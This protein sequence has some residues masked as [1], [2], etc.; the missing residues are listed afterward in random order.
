MATR[1]EADLVLQQYQDRLFDSNPNLVKLSVVPVT[2]VDGRSTSEYLLEAGV[3]SMAVQIAASSSKSGEFVPEGLA[4]PDSWNGNEVPV[5][6]IQVGEIKALNNRHSAVSAPV[7]TLEFVGRVRPVNGG[8]SVGNTRFNSAG[9]FGSV[10]KLR[11]D[12]RN[13][14]F[15]SNWHV[16]AGGAGVPGDAI[17]QP[18]RLD[19]GSTPNDEIGSLFWF[20]LNDEF[21]VALGL[22]RAP[23][24]NFVAHG[25]RCFSAYSDVPVDP[26]VGRHVTKCGRTTETTHGTILSTNAT[27]RVTGAYPGGVQRFVKQIETTGMAMA[28]D[29]GSVTFHSADMSP[30]GLLFAGDSTRTYHNNLKKLFDTQFG[31]V[32]TTN[33]IGTPITLPSVQ[34]ERL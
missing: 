6:V 1:A 4:V 10:V 20:L 2:D 3:I 23:W 15:I 27:V 7:G 22:S 14:Y 30:V 8:N 28:G 25:F 5:R 9:T 33:S 13:R 21:D 19:G 16:L 34:M 24:Q 12:V 11:D 17:L 32:Q 31:M 29:S 26:V 18:G